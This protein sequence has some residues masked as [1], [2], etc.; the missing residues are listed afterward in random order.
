MEHYVTIAC[1]SVSATFLGLFAIIKSC[2]WLISLKY[3]T[4]DNFELELKKF[5]E[6]NLKSFASVESHQNLKEDMSEIK[7]KLDDIHNVIM[8]FAVHNL[9]G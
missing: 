4:K 8:T 2:D 7:S 9:K 6:K 3:L 1:V 5:S